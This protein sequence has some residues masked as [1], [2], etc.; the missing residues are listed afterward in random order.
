MEELERGEGTVH[1]SLGEGWFP[2]MPARTGVPFVFI[3]YLF[4]FRILV[5]LL[6]CIFTYFKFFVYLF[7]CIKS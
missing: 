1:A 5:Q 7:H 2:K 4:I 6:K 3:F